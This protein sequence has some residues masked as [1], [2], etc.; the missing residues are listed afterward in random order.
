MDML[1]SNIDGNH[2]V[3]S[4]ALIWIH[5]ILQMDHVLLLTLLPEEVACLVWHFKFPPPPPPPP[6]PLP[7]PRRRPPRPRPP[8]PPLPL[9]QRE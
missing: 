9:V 2:L 7:P 6:P 1:Q 5:L 3:L 8:R 4:N